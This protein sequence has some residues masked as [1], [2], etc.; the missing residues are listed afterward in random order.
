MLYIAFIV[1]LRVYNIAKV[2][3]LYTFV[4]S[5][6]TFYSLLTY[7]IITFLFLLPINFFKFYFLNLNISFSRY[8]NSLLF[9]IRD[10]VVNKM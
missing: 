7:L 5:L 10:G 3:Y 4:P 8:F 1:S 2:Y 9:I 6:F